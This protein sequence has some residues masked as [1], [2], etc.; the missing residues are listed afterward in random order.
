[1]VKRAAAMAIGALA[2]SS[3]L[4]PRLDEMS[5]SRD[6]ARSNLLV[7]DGLWSQIDRSYFD[8]NFNGLD[9]EAVE[10]EF[11]PKARQAEDRISLYWN[12]LRPMTAL[13]ESSHTTVSMAG[14]KDAK[15]KHAASNMSS[16]AKLEVLEPTLGRC[17]GVWIVSGASGVTPKVIHVET[18]SPAY[19]LGIRP[20]WR[21][22]EIEATDEGGLR[23]VTMLDRSGKLHKFSGKGRSESLFVLGLAS[24]NSKSIMSTALKLDVK[25][26]ALGKSGM[27]VTK[28][29]FGGPPVVAMVEPH[30]L[31]A[32]AGI[33]PGA[34]IKSVHAR[35]LKTNAISTSGTYKNP[36]G[37][38]VQFNSVLLCNIDSD[39]LVEEYHVSGSDLYIRFDHFRPG[40]AEWIRGL[41]SRHKGQVILDLRW[42]SGGSALELEQVLGLFLIN[43]E[44]IGR[45]RSRYKDQTLTA[46]N[47]GHKAFDGRLSVLASGVTASAAEVAVLALKTAGAR[48]IGQ[49]TSGQVQLSNTYLLPDGGKA[50]VAVGEFYSASGVVLEGRG[51]APDIV[52]GGAKFP[53][54]A[55]ADAALLIAQQGRLE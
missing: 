4:V 1:M 19:N 18:F 35:K 33:V 55:K 40:V 53:F 7:F 47:S 31:A 11:R 39:S 28:G 54:L 26:V 49:T 27:V 29:R 23:D 9:W 12:V 6:T 37:G 48:V 22:V 5:K 36:D 17:G 13:L 30:S 46:K 10:V 2:L 8:P 44:I 42:N 21:F 3:I 25:P 34:T 52:V 20:G 24:I 32:Q 38:S 15:A 41:L 51:V 43:H 50:S 45:V 14:A 16:E